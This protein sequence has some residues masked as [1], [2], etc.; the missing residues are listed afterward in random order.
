MQRAGGDGKRDVTSSGADGSRS[1]SN[2]Y[3]EKGSDG[4]DGEEEGLTENLLPSRWSVL[5]LR[6]EMKIPEHYGHE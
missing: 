3:G 2:I 1:I 6:A 4:E 5:Y